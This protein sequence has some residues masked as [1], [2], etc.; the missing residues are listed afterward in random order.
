MPLH[1]DEEYHRTISI[2]GE[3]AA[4]SRWR[5]HRNL[6]LQQKRC[7]SILDV[8]CSSGGFLNTLKN[9][10]WDLYGIEME[11]ATAEKARATTGAHVFVGDVAHAP[12]P[13][14]HFDVITCFDILEHVYD[15]WQLLTRARAWLK[16]GG[17]LYTVLPNIE[18]WESRL[19]GS[20]WYGLELPR[21]LF[22]FSP[23]SLRHIMTTL[24]FREAR[25]TTR[26]SYIERSVGYLYFELFR[27]FAASLPA[28][29]S[30]PRTA[31]F[32]WRAIRKLLRL[33]IV[34]PF[35]ELASMA[36]AGASI[37][38]VFVKDY[39]PAGSEPSVPQG[40]GRIE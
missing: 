24:A 5:R 4:A 31:S 36:G 23:A 16:P 21:H 26:N 13:D 30:K 37:E 6:L 33:A 32:A 10:G 25:L 2:A 14:E 39:S 8:G 38:A 15:P 34:R 27:Q 22:H 40:G 18:S 35:A 9:D 1:Y 3:S 29:P 28:P 12:F 17:I 7:G 19:L 11:P 20:Y